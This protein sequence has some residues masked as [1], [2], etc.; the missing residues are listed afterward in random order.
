MEVGVEWRWEENGVIVDKGENF[1]FLFV[2]LVIILYFYFLFRNNFFEVA[3]I[4]FLCVLSILFI[5]L[6]VNLVV[7][8]DKKIFD[9]RSVYILLEKFKF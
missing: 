3:F 5:V 4:R 7:N 1:G 8:I 6:G 9:F 2:F